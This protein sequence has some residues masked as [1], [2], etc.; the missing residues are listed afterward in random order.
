MWIL[1][2]QVYSHKWQAD[3]SLNSKK[4]GDAAFRAKDYATAIECYTRVSILSLKR[5]ESLTEAS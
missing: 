3:E 4:H 5:L 1:S 2:L